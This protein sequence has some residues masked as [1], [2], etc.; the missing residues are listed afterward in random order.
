MLS[1]IVLL[2]LLGAVFTRV[3]LRAQWKGLGLWL[4]RCVDLAL[5]VLAIIYGVQLLVITL[6]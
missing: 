1:K 4:S 5:V 3:F 2:L 6:R